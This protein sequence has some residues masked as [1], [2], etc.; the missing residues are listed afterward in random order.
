MADNNYLRLFGLLDKKLN[1][2]EKKI[3]EKL[4]GKGGRIL[5]RSNITGSVALIE[6]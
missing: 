1:Y 6:N 2:D 3:R 5:P 4:P